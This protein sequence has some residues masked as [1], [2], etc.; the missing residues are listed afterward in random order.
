M[1]SMQSHTFLWDQDYDYAIPSNRIIKSTYSMPIIDT[2]GCEYH[3]ILLPNNTNTDILG[4]ICTEIP[5]GT[6]L[7]RGNSKEYDTG[8][9][10]L[11]NKKTFYYF[12]SYKF[13]DQPYGQTKQY[14]INKNVN[15]LR[16]DM[17]DNVKT[18]YDIVK[19]INSQ[20]DTYSYD[21][22]R[23]TNVTNENKKEFTTLLRNMA[24]SIKY[25]VNNAKLKGTNTSLETD[26][27]IVKGIC[28]LNWYIG[29]KDKIHGYGSNPIVKKEPPHNI[30]FHSEIMLCMQ[31]DYI[32]YVTHCSKT[33]AK[34]CEYN[35]GASSCFINNYIN[36][37]KDVD[38]IKTNIVYAT[39]KDGDTLNWDDLDEYINK[40]YINDIK[41]IVVNNDNIDEKINLIYDILYSHL[42]DKGKE[43]N[44]IIPYML[45]LSEYD[46]FDEPNIWDE[47]VE[48]GEPFTKEKYVG[49]IH[50]TIDTKIVSSRSYRLHMPEDIEDKIKAGYTTKS[51]DHTTTSAGGA[52]AG[53]SAAR[54][55]GGVASGSRSI[56]KR[57]RRKTRRKRKNKNSK[58][59]QRT[60]RKNHKKGKTHR[61]KHIQN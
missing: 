37:F 40:Q 4:L 7:Y 24:S 27:K 19:V 2:K 60:Y 8:R 49:F 52:A 23:L 55:D 18:L 50:K 30:V 31:H 39:N 42:T 57:R 1:A 15:I 16:I 34:K 53:A 44:Q 61:K 12:S 35:E 21:G 59:P 3:T 25:K 14:K 13:V 10:K 29:T 32:D 6:F 26:I 43:N 58:K 47:F 36:L 38:N 48:D 46:I 54:A 56:N 28:S 5:A 45:L 20:K 17:I 11:D 9:T 41:E 51:D 22:T 33:Y